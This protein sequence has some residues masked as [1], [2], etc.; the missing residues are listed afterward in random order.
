MQV[1]YDIFKFISRALRKCIFALV[2]I[3]GLIMSGLAGLATLLLGLF[4]DFDYTSQIVQDID[5]ASASLAEQF[6]V[7]RY[8]SNGVV[9]IL[10]S[11]LAVDT[12]VECLVLLVGATIAIVVCTLLTFLGGVLAVAVSILIVR[13]ILKIVRVCS[14]GFVDP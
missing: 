6:Q 9:D 4:A 2:S 12:L 13:G 14:G 3:P 5:R 11:F 7:I 8:S 10:V 1:I